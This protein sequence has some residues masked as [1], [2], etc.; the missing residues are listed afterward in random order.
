M[1]NHNTNRFISIYYMPY[2]LIFFSRMK[3]IFSIHCLYEL[4]KIFLSSLFLIIINYKRK[5]FLICTCTK[6][7]FLTSKQVSHL[8]FSTCT[9]ELTYNYIIGTKLSEIIPLIN[10][11]RACHYIRKKESFF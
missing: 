11:Y 2:I 6:N 1:I 7:L 4:I 9:P 3:F 5:C 8:V 10:Y